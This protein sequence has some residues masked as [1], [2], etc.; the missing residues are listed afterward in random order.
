MKMDILL[1][2]KELTIVGKSHSVPGAETRI[3]SGL[4]STHV[5]VAGKPAS[6]AA[7]AS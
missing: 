2:A 7:S 6:I 3:F 4:N 1:T 5:P